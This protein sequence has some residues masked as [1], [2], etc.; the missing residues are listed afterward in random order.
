MAIKPGTDAVGITVPYGA[1]CV[2]ASIRIDSSFQTE[3]MDVVG[4]GFHAVGESRGM[5]VHHANRITVA[6]E[7][8]VDVDKLVSLFFQTK[9][10]HGIRLPTNQTVADVHSIRI[11]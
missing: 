8:V 1:T 3:R 4:H 9:G 7:S 10:C 11:P 2:A 6:E 5:G